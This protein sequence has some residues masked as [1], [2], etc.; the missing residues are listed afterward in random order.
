MVNIF[1]ST[2]PFGLYDKAPRE[3]LE[4]TG[5]NISYNSHRRKLKPAELAELAIDCE[6]LVAGTED[7][8]LLVQAGSKLKFI[9]RVG[10]GLDSVPIPLCVKKGIKVSYTPDAVTAAVAELTLGFMIQLP[11]QVHIADREIRKGG[12]SRP[13][14]KRLGESV[15][16][17]IGCGRVGQYV[18]RLLKEFRP[19]K[20][21]IN[22][23]TD[24]SCQVKTILENTAIS[25]QFV[26]KEEI[27]SSA[28]VITVHTPLTELTKKM[29]S[30]DQLKKFQKTAYL[31]NTARGEI[32]E[33]GSLYIALK[34][35][36]IAGAAID[37][38]EE[39]P[40]HGQLIELENT[41]LTEHIG[42]CSFDC[43]LLMELGAA[44]EM[45]RFF[46]GEPLQNEIDYLT[47]VVDVL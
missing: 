3:A 14:G 36:W 17:I 32:V 22:D 21:L 15:I 7:L 34:N 19:Q 25:Y 47:S 45:V 10:I 5:W 37:V 6:G 1:V 43:R 8:T 35:N 16:G 12:W 2:Y 13:V 41:I 30:L 9:S 40:Y 38:Y 31:I 11:R 39:E 4:K 26:S 46:Q 42:S 23:I 44:E 27:F 24:V 28:D 18:L 20:V 29:I 33:E